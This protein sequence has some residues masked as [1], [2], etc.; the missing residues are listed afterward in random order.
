MHSTLFPTITLRELQK[1]K[2]IWLFVSAG[3]E[4][5][6][7]IRKISFFCNCNLISAIASVKIFEYIVNL[8]SLLIKKNPHQKYSWNFKIIEFHRKY[9][10]NDY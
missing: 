6:E 5:G 9:L 7:I 8:C 2:K 3:M 10:K 1:Q 4:I